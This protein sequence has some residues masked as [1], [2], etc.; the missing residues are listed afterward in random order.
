M[1][2]PPPKV[3][4]IIKPKL[5]AMYKLTPLLLA[6]VL[7]ASLSSCRKFY[8]YIEHHP[9]AQD[10]ACRVTK[11]TIGT[12]EFDVLYNNK[13]NPTD[14]L[15]PDPRTPITTTE[16]H[17]R[18]DRFDRLTDYFVN[19]R[20]GGYGSGDGI[21]RGAA[22]IWDKYGYPKPNIIS[23]TFIT[24]PD[25]AVFINDP[26]P[27]APPGAQI[28]LYKFNAAGK[29]IATA[30]TVNL[31]NQPAPV[32][33][34]IA[35]D[36]RGNRDLS[37]YTKV[38]YDSSISIYRTNKIWQ[39]V[40]NDYSRNN[41]VYVNPYFPFQLPT[42]TNEFGL[43]T[44]LPYITDNVPVAN[45]GIGSPSYLGDSIHIEYACAVPRSYM[46]Y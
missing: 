39:L 12:V 35:Y 19:Y 30:Q 34:D 42:P 20:I 27:I 36:A 26:A 3:P 25:P 6:I 13:G 5:S 9:D 45:F 46:K 43:P 32:F 11:L 21:F 22:V 38:L 40:F 17:F 41:V 8:E 2:V 15:V 23:D 24:Y 16:K 31:P 29:M 10:N 4:S 44:A 33:S 7:V 37:I 18:Y 1:P 14:I 28:N